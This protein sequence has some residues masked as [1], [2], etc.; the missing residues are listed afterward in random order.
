MSAQQMLPI[1][2]LLPKMYDLEKIISEITNIS[3][4][5]IIPPELKN[6]FINIKHSIPQI[7]VFGSQ[8]SGKSSV[9][10]KMFQTNLKTG[11]GMCT[12]CPIEIRYDPS[13]KKEEFFVI[14]EHNQLINTF[15]TFEEA[16]QCIDENSQGQLLPVFIIYQKPSNDSFIITDLPGFHINYNKTYFDYLKHKYYMLLVAIVIHCQTFPE[17][18]FKTFQIK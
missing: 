5:N 12:K 1:Q 10:N 4:I 16:Q 15:H 14:N 3:K 8:S 17:K 9:L 7:V 6:D 11:V 13:Y 2:Q 18:S